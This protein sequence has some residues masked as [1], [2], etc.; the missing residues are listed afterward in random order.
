MSFSLEVVLK[1][2]ILKKSSSFQATFVGRLPNAWTFR[3]A[4]L[5]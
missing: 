5:K 1:S 4:F 3:R 2:R